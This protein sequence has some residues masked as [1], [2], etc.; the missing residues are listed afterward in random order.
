MSWEREVEGIE[1]RRELAQE[2]G[3]SEAGAKHHARGRL[4]VRE[5]IEDLVDAGSP[6]IHS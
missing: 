1:R 6:A 5:R 2:Q 4:T 3:G